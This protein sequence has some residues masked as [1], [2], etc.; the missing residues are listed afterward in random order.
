MRVAVFSTKG[1]DREFLDAA[2][3]QSGHDLHYFESRL[4]TETC[5]LVQGFEAVC[6]FVNDTVDR[7]VLQAM[8]G[9]GGKLLALRSAGFSHVDLK[10]AVEMGIKVARVPAYSLHA[11]AEHTLALILALNRHVHRAF[12][13][14]RERN[15]AL[16]GLLGFDM[17]KKTVGVVGTGQIGSVFTKLMFGFGCE[18]LGHDLRPNDKCL[19]L[20]MKYVSLEELLARSHIISLH[21]PLTPQTRHLIN[22]QTVSRM[23]P[24]VMIVNTSRGA[25]VDTRAVIEGL[26]NG[27]IGSLALDVY[28]KEGDLFFEDLSDKVIQDDVF[29]RLLTFP[30]VL[31]TGHQGFFTREALGNIAETTLANITAF[32]T[33]RGEFHEVTQ[34]M[35]LGGAA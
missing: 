3:W 23:R 9:G 6:V 34:D 27:R 22:G 2:N 13:R 26:K 17:H 25:I 18:L 21:C 19:A 31:I 11:V 8:A 29:A 5:S 7:A 24:G 32:A 14:V 12:N 28:E 16:D 15:F 10:A 33:G 35:V 30:N 1:Y 4:N 20:G